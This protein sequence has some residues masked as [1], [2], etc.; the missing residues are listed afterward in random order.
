MNN[1]VV[2]VSIASPRA[3]QIVKPREIVTPGWKSSR[4]KEQREGQGEVRLIDEDAP[5]PKRADGAASSSSEVWIV[6][7]FPYLNSY[8]WCLT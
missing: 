4:D 5:A 2:P 1:I 7:S 6:I 8:L 3:L